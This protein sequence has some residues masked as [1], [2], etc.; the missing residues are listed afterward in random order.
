MKR[1]LLLIVC[2]TW[3][4]PAS[5]AVDREVI[6]LQQDVALLQGM[7]RELQRSFDEKMAVVQTL[8]GQSSQGFGQINQST[9]QL[10][11]AIANLEK[12]V[13]TSNANA[14]QKIDL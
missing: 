3:L 2:I 11:S 5:F 8:L 6:K 12:N 14:G 4:A 9:G 13:Q 1:V 7:M 10:S